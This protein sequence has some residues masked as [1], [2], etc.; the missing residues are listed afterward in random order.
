MKTADF[1]V[2]CI[3]SA[4]LRLKFVSKRVE[5]GSFRNGIND[6]SFIK[7]NNPDIAGRGIKS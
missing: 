6:N 1:A 2:N 4:R 5:Y 3:V 7:C